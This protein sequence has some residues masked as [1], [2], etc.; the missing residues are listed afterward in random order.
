MSSP[1]T[2]FDDV[3]AAALITDESRAAALKLGRSGRLFD[4]DAGRFRAQGGHYAHP[5]FEVVTYRTPRG[6]KVENDLEFLTNNP[7][8]YGFISEMIIG[9]VHTGAHIDALCHVTV[10]EDD[11]WF[12]GVS[13]D[14]YLGDHGAEKSDAME[15]PAIVSRGVLV[16]VAGRKELAELPES[17]AITVDDVTQALEYQGTTIKRGDVVLV[18]TGQMTGWPSKVDRARRAVEAGLTLEA[19][20]WLADHEPVAVGAD[21]SSLEVSPSIKEGYPE[22]VHVHLLIER[23]VY[24]MEWIYLEELAREKAYEFLFVCLPLRIRG[25]TGSMVRA[26]GIV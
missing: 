5:P 10:G 24:I 8:G 11:R 16:D 2:H 19:A 6:E 14:E 9:S 3:G 13:A 7:K 15:L 4:L 1:K 25:A 17:Y 21:N 12:G 18:R 26:V 22:P 23:G 20:K